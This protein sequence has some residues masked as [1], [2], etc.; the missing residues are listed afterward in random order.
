ML[1]SDLLVAALILLISCVAIL[2]L[3]QIASFCNFIEGIVRWLWPILKY[4]VGFLLSL[5]LIG[6]WVVIRVILWLPWRLSIKLRNICMATPLH[7][8]AGHRMN[9]LQWICELPLCFLSFITNR[10]FQIGHWGMKTGM[11]A[12]LVRHKGPWHGHWFAF[13][14][15]DAELHGGELSKGAMWAASTTGP[16]WNTHGG[17]Q[18]AVCDLPGGSGI[19]EIENL[20]HPGLWWRACFHDQVGNE[21]GKIVPSQSSDSFLSIHIDLPSFAI[22][23]E[24]L[25]E[26]E[27]EEDSVDNSQVCCTKE[28]AAVEAESVAQEQLVFSDVSEKLTIW[29]HHYFYEDCT[30]APIPAVRIGGVEVVPR[31]KCDLS[32]RDFISGLRPRQ[33]VAYLA[34]HWYVFFMLSHKSLLPAKYID[35][36][37]LY[38]RDSTLAIKHGIAIEGLCLRF[39]TSQRFL[40]E[41]LVFCTVYSRASMP[42]IGDF[43]MKSTVEVMHPCPEDGFWQIRIVRRDNADVATDCGNEVEVTLTRPS[44]N[45]AEL[46]R[47]K[48][49]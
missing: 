25:E 38:M 9:P 13:L 48:S 45:D 21:L 30:C 46:S 36:D 19:V 8:A 2:A 47:L 10:Y 4:I 11:P 49:D 40:D 33:N 20:R 44:E 18:M 43:R 1:F 29:V 32:R 24:V 37:M 23:Q 31:D 22:R 41:H 15:A 16:R 34:Q 35:S 3:L 12:G 17:S 14:E 39:A 27:E 5:C 42:V 28:E 26:D 7:P 6:S